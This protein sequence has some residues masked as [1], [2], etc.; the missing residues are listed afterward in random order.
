MKTAWQIITMSLLLSLGACAGSNSGSDADKDTPADQ[1]CREPLENQM[2]ETLTNLQTD[3]DFT[4][5]LEAED[6]G[7]FTYSN[8]GLSTL[9]TPYESASTSK[10]VTA[11]VILRLVDLGRLSLD[12]HPQ[13][14]ILDW[15][16]DPSDPLYEITLAQLLSFT[17]GLV[18][19]P[20][21]INQPNAN[22]AACV[23]QIAVANAA[24]G[25]VPGAEFDYG[26]SHMQVAGLMAMRA[27]D[28][29]SWRELFLQFKQDTGLFPNAAY[30]LP[31]ISNPRL[32][33]GMHWQAQEYAAFLKA[34]QFGT[35]LSEGTKTLMMTDQIADAALG[36]IPTVEGIDQEWHY[37]FGIWLECPSAAFDC[38]VISYYSSPGAYGAYPFINTEQRF[39]GV[40]ARQGALG[41]FANGKAVYDAVANLAEQWA[42]C[43]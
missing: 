27:A 2:T 42:T 7:N 16:I 13:D 3:T 12:D 8:K 37:G 36:N 30:D 33:G 25:K 10:W 15:S 6:G 9:N 26:P 23:R 32:A 14:H 34:F 39:F 18:N 38:P 21:C 35:L 41:T 1:V 19:E 24:N 5:Y 22:F 31:S 43:Q 17:S 28:V 20:L 11:A 4:L 29:T 40:L